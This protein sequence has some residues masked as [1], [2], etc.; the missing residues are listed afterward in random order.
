MSVN[1]G[2][3]QLFFPIVPGGLSRQTKFYIQS[4]AICES[5]EASASSWYHDQLERRN[6]G[7]NHGK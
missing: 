5:F 4:M 3:L 2:S 6:K 1:L 7:S